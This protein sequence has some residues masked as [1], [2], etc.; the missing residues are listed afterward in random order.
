[1]EPHNQSYQQIKISVYELLNN[2][3]K[4]IVLFGT[5]R[6]GKSHLVNELR[7]EAHDILG[8][9]TLDILGQRIL[10][11]NDYITLDYMASKGYILMI[12]TLDFLDNHN[13]EDG[14]YNLIDMDHLHY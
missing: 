1:M 8:I 12:N 14:D 11:T 5:G 13:L 6:N 7:N 2:K 10:Y 9:E 4:L 3:D